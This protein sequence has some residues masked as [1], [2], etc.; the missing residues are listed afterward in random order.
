MNI[1]NFFKRRPEPTPEPL[2]DLAQLPK[3]T[4]RAVSE[5]D[6]VWPR[7]VRCDDEAW[8]YHGR[9]RIFETVECA[10][11]GQRLRLAHFGSDGGTVVL[12]ILA[13]KGNDG[14]KQQAPQT[15]REAQT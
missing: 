12:Q 11:C 1:L 7:C 2:T 6:H 9:E 3:R 5:A 14:V 13:Y 15:R 4:P 10:G 8:L